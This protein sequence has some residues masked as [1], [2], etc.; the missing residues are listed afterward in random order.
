METYLIISLVILVLVVFFIA[1]VW[2]FLEDSEKNYESDGGKAIE[3]I[4]G[5]KF[6][7][8]EDVKKPKQKTK[9]SSKKESETVC[10]VSELRTN[11][12]KK[13][14]K[15]SK[16]KPPVSINAPNIIS[17]GFLYAEDV[18]NLDFNQKYPSDFD[19]YPK[20]HSDEPDQKKNFSSNSSQ[21][22]HENSEHQP[23]FRPENSDQKVKFSSN[24]L[25]DFDSVPKS[26]PNPQLNFSAS[27]R[28]EDHT[29]KV[30]FHP[31]SYSDRQPGFEKN[32]SDNK[33]FGH[34]LTNLDPEVCLLSDNSKINFT[35][36]N[37]RFDFE[38]ENK[39]LLA[40]QYYMQNKDKYPLIIPA[41]KNYS[42]VELAASIPGT[43]K[44]SNDG[45]SKGEKLCRSALENIFGLKF[46]SI[47]PNILQN[48]ES[49][50]NLEFD[51][52]NPILKIAFEYNGKQHYEFPN[53]FHKT[54]EEFIEQVRK[55]IYK[56]QIAAEQGIYLITIPYKVKSEYADIY[57]YIIFWL[58]EN[59][60][61]R[62]QQ[63]NKSKDK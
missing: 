31:N 44:K 8:D 16:S 25:I 11:K 23:K 4:L 48:P 46:Y 62:E 33:Q 24:N 49:G 43:I 50:H 53:G 13:T 42:A 54:K 32:I 30:G 3:E 7:F 20:F 22:S 45:E 60:K 19:H 21:F 61:Y 38:K 1:L 5:V 2:Y 27:F 15:K 6:G 34:N 39:T 14:V 56:R 59:V 47:R 29:E 40:H 35:V 10:E 41:K 26:N 12:G 63:K 58:P 17:P 55:D 18:S 28:P 57:K 36:P 37:K 9:K 51:G 52:Y